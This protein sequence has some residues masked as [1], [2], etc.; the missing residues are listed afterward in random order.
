VNRRIRPY[1]KVERRK[2]RFR[3]INGGPSRF[4]QLFLNSGKPFI[5]ITGDGNF[6]PEPVVA[7]SIYLSVAQRVDVIIDFSQYKVGE[8]IVLQNRLEQTNGRGPSGRFLDPPDGILRLDVIDATGPDPSRVRA[9]QSLSS[10]STIQIWQHWSGP[11]VPSVLSNRSISHRASSRERLHGS[12][13][14]CETKRT[15]SI[16]SPCLTTTVPTAIE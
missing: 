10:G 13:R 4:Y 8:Q 3:I 9:A 14:A 12:T 16:P 15:S 2:Y 6:Q 5:I 7:E 11:R 1:F